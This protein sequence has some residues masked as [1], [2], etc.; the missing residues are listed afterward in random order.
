MDLMKLRKLISDVKYIY[1]LI[2][3]VSFSLFY[4]SFI[5]C[6]IYKPTQLLYQGLVIFGIVV[7]V[8]DFFISGI[9]TRVKYGWLLVLFY[10]ASLVSIV[11]N[12]K[13][14]PIGN[15]KVVIW[16]VIQT[17]VFSA[18]DS[19]QDKEY[20]KKY[21]RIIT[22]VFSV[23]WLIGAAVSIVM[24]ISRYEGVIID[25]D[26]SVVRNTVRIGFLE[27]RLFGVFSDPN[28]ASVCIIFSMFMIVSNMLMFR[29]NIALRIYHVALLVIDFI[30]IVL[31]K[32]RTA[33]IC[34]YVSIALAVFFIAKS[35]L[36]A[37]ARMKKLFRYGVAA[38]AA[39]L[40]VIIL[41]ASFSFASFA[42]DKFYIS[43]GSSVS[44]DVD[45]EEI[46]QEL[47]RPD[48]EYSADITN[49][50]A[51]IWADYFKVFEKNKIFGIGPSNGLSYAKEN[52]PD[53]FIVEKGYYYHNGYL[54]VLVGTGI[55]GSV[56]MLAFM[57]LNVVRIVS[58]L[59]NR[60]RN[61][62]DLYKPVVMLSAM[63][64][65]G[66]IMALPLMAIFFNNS[67]CDA[68][69]WFVLGF[70]N[71]LIRISDNDQKPELFEKLTKFMRPRVNA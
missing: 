2:Y 37:K 67:A 4:N 58:Y 8:A 18:L 24:F 55:I 46:Q 69:F 7:L 50:R 26:P 51:E 52:M 1:T 19:K 10:L 61:S 3:I 64:V 62:D 54:A 20:H 6:Y 49:H 53:L 41:M 16:M 39:L 60:G 42:M 43:V 45:E 56:L 70:V 25:P 29:D 44:D 5:H 47:I 65:V 38:L 13:Y 12:L 35:A 21:F 40:S 68:I 14:D 11:L 15:I 23:V 28:Y 33:E 22:E 57:I 34:I 59:A 17:F 27:G 9:L 63:L 31:A 36:F 66:A 32:S 71:C 48:V 30:Y